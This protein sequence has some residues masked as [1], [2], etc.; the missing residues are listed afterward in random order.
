MVAIA[1][2]LDHATRLLSAQSAGMDRQ[3]F[4]DWVICY[5][6]DGVDGL[7]K[8]HKNQLASE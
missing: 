7:Y 6:A 8:F 1:N 3:T 4:R 2:A 5:D